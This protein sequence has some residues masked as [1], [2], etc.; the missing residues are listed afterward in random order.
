[1]PTL[2]GAAHQRKRTPA[3][4]EQNGSPVR[5][6][7][8]AAVQVRS[9]VVVCAALLHACA[10]LLSLAA[11]REFFARCAERAQRRGFARMQRQPRN[12]D[13]QQGKQRQWSE[14]QQKTT[15]RE[16]TDPLAS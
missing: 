13:N 9:V 10:A 14:P 11:L 1:M 7:A 15:H 16:S 2:G 12:G 3:Q 6:C 8:L 4:R 5:R